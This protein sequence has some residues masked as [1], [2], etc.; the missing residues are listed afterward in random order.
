MLELHFNEEPKKKLNARHMLYDEE[1]RKFF[2]MDGKPAKSD[3]FRIC[4]ICAE[5]MQVGQIPEIFRTEY[6]FA[7]HMVE[8]HPKKEPPNTEEM[9]VKE[10]Q[11]YATKNNIDLTGLK[12]KKDILAAIKKG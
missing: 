12:V 8:E 7:K 10:L 1:K 9:T 2:D 11:E 6:D 4:E 3:E 5:K